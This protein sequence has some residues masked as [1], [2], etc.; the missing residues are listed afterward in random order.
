[1]DIFGI[2]VGKKQQLPEAAAV[3]YV[4]GFNFL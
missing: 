2:K 4:V 3:F 1:V